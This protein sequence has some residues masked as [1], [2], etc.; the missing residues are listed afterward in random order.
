MKKRFGK[1]GLMT[2]LCLSLLTSPFYNVGKINTAYAAN[3]A[4]VVRGTLI[5]VRSG[6]GTNHDKVGSLSSGTAVTVTGESTGADGKTWYSITYSGGS[7]YIRSDFVRFSSNYQTE[8]SFEQMLAE[9]GFP[10]SYKT[11]LRH[12]HAEYPNWVFKGFQTNLDWNEA[13]NGEMEGTNSLIDKNSIS[14]WKSTENGKFDWK[15]S[16]WPGFDGATWV[17]ASREITAYYM[18]PRNFLDDKYIFQFAVHS[19]NPATQNI[20]GLKTML[21][22]SFMNSGAAGSSSKT[23]TDGGSAG[24][25]SPVESSSAELPTESRPSEETRTSQTE[26]SFLGYEGPGEVS[27]MVAI[28]SYTARPSLKSSGMK[29]ELMASL[30]ASEIVIGEGP[31]AGLSSNR[32]SGSSGSTG[33]AGIALSGANTYADI[34]MEAAE[35]T[36]QNPYLLAAMI[37]QEQG[38]GNSGSISGSSGYYNYFN[39]GAYAQNGMTAVQRGIW[40]ASQSGSYGRPWNT[41]EKSIVGGAQ[42]FAENY[43][44]AG[45]N[46]LYLKKFN[47]QGANIYKHQYMTNVQGAAE[48]GAKLGAAYTQEMKLLPQEFSIP[49]YRNMP[50]SPSPIPTGDGNPNNK[51]QSLSVDGFSMTP[52]F[53]MDTNQYTL[54]V[55]PSVSTVNVSASAIES[56]ASVSGGGSIALSQDSTEVLVSVK[57]QNGSSR[58]Y[59]ILIKKQS[60]G[61]TGG[62][63]RQS[64]S[65]YASLSPSGSSSGS[66]GVTIIDIGNSPVTG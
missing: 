5:N 64:E 65:S 60:G 18:D 28:G 41:V 58:E 10:E 46:T 33:S 2:L 19:Y 54:L 59:R 12:L 3:R 55:D 66:S 26:E 36:R 31:G 45:Q 52:S 11:G 53:N 34:I 42:F 29:A 51:L 21:Q 22:N 25:E 4:G 1:K 24:A 14:S 40:Y 37:L 44:K 15:T 61:Q 49:I 8:S 23:F 6:A 39:V 43:L 62:Q 27:N 56:R 35:K 47:V 48:E 17:G 38:N 57:A 13:L 63:Q 16:T 7:G 32:A 30:P 50:E 20:D 9:Q